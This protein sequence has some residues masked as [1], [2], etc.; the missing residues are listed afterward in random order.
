MPD[1]LPKA[2]RSLICPI[3]GCPIHD[4]QAVIGVCVDCVKKDHYTQRIEVKMPRYDRPR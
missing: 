1:T 2:I 3:C 4:A